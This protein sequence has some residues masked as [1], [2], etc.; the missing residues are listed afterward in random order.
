M[1]TA[2][3]PEDV[4]AQLANFY[5]DFGKFDQ[6]KEAL[7]KVLAKNEKNAT[8]K[9]VQAKFFLKEGKNQEALD[10]VTRMLVD[11]PK[12]G[13]LFFVKA[14]A[15]SNLKDFRL[16]K[17]ALAEAIKFS[18]GFAK[19]HSLLGL[20]S[21]QEGDFETAKKEAATALKLNPRDFQ[22]ALTLA[23]AVLFSKDY[24]TAEK[25][26]SELHAKVPENVEVLGSLGLAYLALKKEDKAK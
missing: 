13:E 23:K 18:P 8:A 6:S 22:A 25:M 2:E 11:Y 16:A 15:H 12:W 20:L 4:E 3:Q 7:D 26:L 24:E 10:I 17:E 14:V 9:L 19:A 21:L 5:F 1:K